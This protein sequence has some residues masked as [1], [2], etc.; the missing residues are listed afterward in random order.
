MERAGDEI[1]NILRP[2]QLLSSMGTSLISDNTWTEQVTLPWDKR[3]DLPILVTRYIHWAC[4]YESLRL[5]ARGYRWWFVNIG[6]YNGLVPSGKELI[7]A[8]VSIEVKRTRS[9]RKCSVCLCCLLSQL[10][11][12]TLSVIRLETERTRFRKILRYRYLS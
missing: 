10:R 9:I 6:S 3:M 8:S 1:S 12:M 11:N 2:C 7:H 4:V 5:N